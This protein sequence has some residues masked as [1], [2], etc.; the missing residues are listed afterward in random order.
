MVL[1]DYIEHWSLERPPF[2]LA[3][4]PDALYMSC[5]HQDCLLRL[6]FAVHSS[7]GGVLLVSENAGDGKTSL[8]LRLARELKEDLE[9][10]VRLAFIDHPNVTPN[11]LIEEMSRQ[12][13]ARARSSSKTHVMEAFR[14]HLTRI[15]DEGG[16]TIVIVDEGQMLAERPDVLEEL[17]VLLNLVRGDEF[18]L[19]FIFSGQKALEQAVRSR[20]EFWQ[21]LAVRV[22]LGN[23]DFASTRELL[24]FRMRRAGWKRPE[25]AFTPAAV[26]AIQRYSSGCPRVICSVADLALMVG[27]S[28]RSKVVDE[29]EAAQA[30]QDMEGASGESFHYFRFTQG[31]RRPVGHPEGLPRAAADRS[32]LPEPDELEE[33]PDLPWVEV[34]D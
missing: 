10:E 30:V 13:G 19:T 24:D 2:S 23:L 8:L 28:L 4:D 26:A 3:P 29:R 12:L 25:P 15:R 31:S 6:K 7:K 16:R 5:Q 27:W 32:P 18:L 20:P 9:G 34:V 21:R 22:F 14:D 11:Q 33:L 17:R 1:L